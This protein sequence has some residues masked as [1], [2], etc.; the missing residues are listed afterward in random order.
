MHRFLFLIFLFILRSNNIGGV[1]AQGTDDSSKLHR[2]E[3]LSHTESSLISNN[4]NKNIEEGTMTTPAKPQKSWPELVGMDGEE[5]KAKL[6]ELEPEKNII[7]VPAGSGVTR[8]YR[9]N[10]IR[11]FLDKDGKVTR[12]PIIG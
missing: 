1:W 12:T 11:I 2:P 4:N 5:A 7:L 10:R 3:R 6:Q 9:P 8:D